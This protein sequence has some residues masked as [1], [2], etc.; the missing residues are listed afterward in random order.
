MSCR[1]MMSVSATAEAGVRVAGFQ[2]TALPK[3]RAGAIF[4]AG[5][6]TVVADAEGYAQQVADQVKAAGIRTGIDLRNEKI[7]YKVREHSHA[8]VPHLLVVGKREAKE[9]TVA[10]RTLGAEHQKVMPLADAIAMLQAEA[11]APDL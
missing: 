5:V 6:A 9:G 10:I 1:V 2:T 3:A 4:Q 7:N 11:R 8:K